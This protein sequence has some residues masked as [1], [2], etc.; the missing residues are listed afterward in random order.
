M[1][2]VDTNVLLR[3]VLDDHPKEASIAKKLLAQLSTDKKLFIS[4][5]AIL[6]MVWVLK[7]KDYPRKII[8][9]VVLDL[10]DSNG[11]IVGNREIIVSAIERYSNGKAD[12]GDYLIISEGEAYDT[13]KLASFDK[14]LYKEEAFCQYPSDFLKIN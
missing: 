5:Y 8:F 4:S 2:G 9:E 10:I 13:P 7:V 11:I 1:I 6:E 3:A 12:F 14:A